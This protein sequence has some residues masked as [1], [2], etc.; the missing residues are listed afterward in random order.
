MKLIDT[1][2][3]DFKLRFAKEK[4]TSL[5]LEFIKSLAEYEELSHEVVAT[6]KIL[7]QSLFERKVAEVIIGEYRGN[8]RRISR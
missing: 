2:L 4:D 6:E 8:Y 7:R 5:I 1:K 3:K